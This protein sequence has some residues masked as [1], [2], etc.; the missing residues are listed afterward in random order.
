MSKT[1]QIHLVPIASLKSLPGNPR[2][3]SEKAKQDLKQSIKRFGCPDPLI[4][5][6]APNRKNF[7]IGGNFRLSILKELAYKEAPVVFVNISDEKKE[8][9]FSLRL[10]A[11]QG[12]WDFELLKEFTDIDLMLDVGF[13]ENI[14]SAVWDDISLVDDE[15]DNEKELAKITKPE[16]K[17][18]DCYQLGRHK[19]ICGDST[20]SK[21]IE[22]LIGKEKINTILTDPPF[23]LG[24]D[25]QKGLGKKQ[26][27][28]CSKV[29]DKLL[30]EEYRKFLQKALGN[31]L[32]SCHKD[33]HV[34]CYNDQSNI[35]LVQDLY[36]N[37]GI[38][39][40]RVCLWIK[41]NQ[42]VTPQI[43]F[44]KC[45]EACV[46]GIIG[47]PYLAKQQTNFTEI[48]N[49]EIETGNR[50]IE[51]ILDL[52]DIWLVKRLPTSEYC[53][54]TEKPIVLHERPLKRCTKPGDKVLDLFAGSGSLLMA[55]EQLGRTA[56]LVEKDP[57]F[58]DLVIR[59]FS[60]SSSN[61]N[62]KKLTN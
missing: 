30:P 19:L 14:L 29:E 27:Y 41:N 26:K 28:E 15:F 53:H 61:A 23:N 37:L 10:N 42:N 9:E 52:L 18:G 20:D 3:W 55:C 24:Y 46:Y 40:K 7:V 4:V 5:N 8:K 56:Y 58:C 11:N 1:P 25:Y 6:I 43:A 54:P 47:N 32:K 38:T 12:A 60:S 51:D 34:F 45:Y 57:S 59:R 33:A 62:V 39:P 2:H 44:N 50:G 22:K 35:G 36:I 31:G 17:I 49:P 13:E 16:T 48:L 21:V